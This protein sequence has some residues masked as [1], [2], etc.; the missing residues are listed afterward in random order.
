MHTPQS[1]SFRQFLSRGLS[2]PF[3]GENRQISLV[4]F[5][6]LKGTLHEV[7]RRGNTNRCRN[8]VSICVETSN[9]VVC[10]TKRE[11]KGKPYFYKTLNHQGERVKVELYNGNGKTDNRSDVFINPST[12]WVDLR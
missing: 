5:P 3:I 6:E 4:R 9:L 10:I 7:E 12:L 2:H 1:Y 11:E 8:Q